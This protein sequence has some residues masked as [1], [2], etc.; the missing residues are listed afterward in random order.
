[1][2]ASTQAGKPAAGCFYKWCSTITRQVRNAELMYDINHIQQ[3]TLKGE[4]FEASH[5]SWLMVL[6]DQSTARP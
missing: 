6:S 2:L 4:H 5:N 1:M 3:I